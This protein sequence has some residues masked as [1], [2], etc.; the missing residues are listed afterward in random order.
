MKGKPDV[1]V[2]VTLTRH[3]PD[4]HGTDTWGNAPAGIALDAIR[5]LRTPFFDVDSAQNWNEFRSAFSKLDA[6]GQNVVFAD[7]DGNIGY[8]ATGKVPIRASSDGSLPEDGSDNA[9]EWTQLHP[10]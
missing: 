3:G 1:D 7:V 9:H 10:L 6:P 5:R 4:D 8:Q 2:D